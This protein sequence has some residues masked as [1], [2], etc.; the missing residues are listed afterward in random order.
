MRS[1]LMATPCTGIGEGLVPEFGQHNQTR[2]LREIFYSE[3]RSTR[4]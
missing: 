2:F 1:S 4:M 3:E